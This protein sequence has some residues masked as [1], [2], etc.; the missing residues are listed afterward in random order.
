MPSHA[1]LQVPTA[2][3]VFPA[4]GFS[5][6]PRA[7]IEQTWNVQQFKQFEAGGHFP[8]LEEP[9]RQSPPKPKCM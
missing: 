1:C 3:A 5:Q 8:A 6:M 4:D 9:G 7:W 2:I